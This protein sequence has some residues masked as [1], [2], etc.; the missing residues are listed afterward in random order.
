MHVFKEKTARPPIIKPYLPLPAR[1]IRPKRPRPIYSGLSGMAQIPVAV[2]AMAYK[3]PMDAPDLNLSDQ[4]DNSGDSD[5]FDEFYDADDVTPPQSDSDD[6]SDDNEQVPD[7]DITDKTIEFLE[8][9]IWNN[10][11]DNH[12]EYV[13]PPNFEDGGA[14]WI[15]IYRVS[16]VSL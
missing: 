7:D 6:S 13:M 3:M 15:G 4:L 5:E 1:P 2:M 11:E 8:F 16:F 9:N 12:V 14:D 10:S